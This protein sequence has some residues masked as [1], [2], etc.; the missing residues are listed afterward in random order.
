MNQKYRLPSLMIVTLA[1]FLVLP[2]KAAAGIQSGFVF[3]NHIDTHQSTYLVTKNGAPVS[4]VGS[5]YIIFT[6]QTDP[7][8]NLPIARHPRGASQNETCGVDVDCA[9]G[10]VI[11]AVPGEGKFLFHTGVNGE[12]HPVWLVNRIQIPQ[13]GDYT[14]FHWITSSSTDPRAVDVPAQCDA[15]DAGNLEGVAED[16]ICPGWF[17]QITATRSF[18]FQ[19]GNEIV[20]VR[21][22]RDNATHL[23][24]L[25]N[26]AAVPGITSIR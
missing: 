5:F 19:H 3:G 12:D 16:I 11:N 13:P 17:L 25:T 10:W 4:L 18:A 6:G 14:H 2:G 1:G 9:T 24:L 20:P 23:N 21:K 22:G 26:Y 7:V 8:S 15:Q